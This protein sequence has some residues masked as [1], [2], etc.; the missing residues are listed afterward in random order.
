M[1]FP[2]RFK[3]YGLRDTV[4]NDEAVF[5]CWDWQVF[6]GRRNGLYISGRGRKPISQM[7]QTIL[8]CK[9]K[10]KKKMF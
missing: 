3:V 7:L 5:H 10:N 8:V 9:L 2:V 6:M 4:P 1:E